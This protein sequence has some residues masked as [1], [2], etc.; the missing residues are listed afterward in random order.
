MNPHTFYIVDVFAESKYAGNQLA[1][2]MNPGDL[3]AA[4]MQDMARETHFSETTFLS[5]EPANNGGYDVRIFTP[6]TEIPFAGHPTLG[7]AFI[8]R[9]ELAHAP[10]DTILLNEKVGPIPVTFGDDIAWMKQ[11]PPTF[12]ET[13]NAQICAETLGIERALVDERYPIQVV[14]TGLAFMIVPLKSLDALRRA[15][16]NWERYVISDRTFIPK[17]ILAFS[18]ETEQPENQLHV[19]CFPEEYGIVED[20]ATGSGNGC[21]AGY[22]ARY[23]YFGEPRVQVRVEQGYEI[24][25]P[26]LLFLRAVEENAALE[27]NVG[28]HVVLVA[29]GEFV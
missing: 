29:R 13:L 27:V 1:V 15:K 2:F 11:N 22:L 10:V 5:P 8:A 20:P 6:A 3:S 19:R 21:L 12:G 26:S 28:G 16:P 4:E 25:R 23:R 7:T 24:A 18:P 17:A 9:R 14:S